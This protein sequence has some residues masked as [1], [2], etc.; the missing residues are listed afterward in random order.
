MYNRGMLTIPHTIVGAALGSFVTD[1]P[2]S[3]AIAFGAGWASHYVLDKVPHWENIFGKDIHGYPSGI[4]LKDIPLVGIAS[5]VV[6]VGVAALVITLIAKGNPEIAFWSNPI[7]WGA[8]G[9][10]FPDLIDNIPLVNK[11]TKYIPGVLAE[12][13]FHERNHISEQARRQV[14]VWWGVVSQLLVVALGLYVL[15][16]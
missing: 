5:G 7:V 1:L 4:E 15:L 8:L 14:P 6:D 2:G 12:R 11:V 16:A 10:F 3:Q 9:G 13:A